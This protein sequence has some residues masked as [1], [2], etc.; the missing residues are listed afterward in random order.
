MAT[1]EEFEDIAPGLERWHGLFSQFWS[2][3]APR[4]TEK[5]PT[6]AIAFNRKGQYVEFIFNPGFWDKLSATAREFVIC[7]ECLHVNLEH[8]LR[9]VNAEQKKVANLAMDVV[10]NHT[11]IDNFGFSHQDLDCVMVDADP[12][13]GEP[14]KT[15][16]EI[17][18]WKDKLYE[19][20][21]KIDD[22][23]TFEYYY[24]KLMERVQEMIDKGQISTDG[25]GI[26]ISMPG[27]GSPLD[28]DT[29]DSHEFMEG[30]DP[31][32]ADGEPGDEEI[33]GK[34][35]KGL[36]GL[37]SIPEDVMDDMIDEV[38]RQ[39]NPDENKQMTQA[40]VGRGDKTYKVRYA[41]R[42]ALQK[43]E[44]LV[45]MWTASGEAPDDVWT[46]KHRRHS[47]LPPEFMMPS[48]YE[49]DRENAKVDVWFF[50]DISGSC[51]SFLDD[52]YNA[53]RTFPENFFKLRMFGFDTGV[54]EVDPKNPNLR[55][56]GGTSF[57]CIEQ[58]IQDKIR[59]TG[60]SHPDAV[61][62]FTDGCGNNVSPQYPDR[63]H[64]FLEGH[65]Q[66]EHNI[67]RESHK[68]QLKD[69]VK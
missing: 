65:Y 5:I 18:I 31:Q 60:C 39:L 42:Q 8:G 68:Y 23:E 38:R 14:A 57:T 41:K 58:A 66:S 27:E 54:I 20:P 13:K 30:G 28:Q 49:D 64:W 1:Y 7:H 29:I 35:D 15:L 6:A 22:N 12:E 24:R 44:K 62:V 37:E 55:A 19:D 51:T 4:F 34:P 3:G 63:W 25:E 52:F 53:A 46:R 32:S 9:M 11:L 33:D 17:L 43:W 50:Q 2:M 67:P 40:G 56:G 10:V 59:Q 48:E 21:S 47:M 26:P 61:F 16:D 36:E 45:Q 69:F